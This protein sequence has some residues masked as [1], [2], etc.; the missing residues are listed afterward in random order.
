[1]A[2]LV[3]TVANANPSF[4]KKCAEAA[5]A[6]YAVSEALKD[7]GRNFETISSNANVLG[8]RNDGTPNSSIVSW[9]YTP[10]ASNP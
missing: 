6:Q 8:L 10:V 4:D 1:M 2:L 9:T 7:F 5:Y 3:I